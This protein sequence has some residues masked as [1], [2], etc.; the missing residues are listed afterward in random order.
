[1]YMKN[2]FAENIAQLR[3]EQG[4]T[5]K[6]LAEK[7]GVITRTVSHWETGGQECSLDMLIKIACFFSVTTDELLGIE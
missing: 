3:K 6:E 1:M 2:K 7:L 4:L 5:Q